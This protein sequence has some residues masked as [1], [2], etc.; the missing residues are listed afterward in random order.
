MRRIYIKMCP[1][2]TVVEFLYAGIHSHKI[3]NDDMK[4]YVQ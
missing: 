2:S 4:P 3:E 1:G